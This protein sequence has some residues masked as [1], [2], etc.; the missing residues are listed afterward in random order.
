MVELQLLPLMDYSQLLTFVRAFHDMGNPHSPFHGTYATGFPLS[1]TMLP[2]LLMDLIGRVSSIETGGRVL[3]TAY[4]VGLPAAAAFLLASVGQSRWNV[5]G[6][7]P[8]V[9]GKWVN[10]G[11]FSFATGGP[12]VLLAFALA[13]RHFSKPTLR[14][15]IALALVSS[16][17]LLWHAI[18]ISEALLGVGLLWLFWRA[19]SW[20]ARWASLLPFLLPFLLGLAWYTQTFKG[21]RP[22]NKHTGG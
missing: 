21:P 10:S 8:L 13:V 3:V 1:P 11:Y 17:L 6:V 22:G 15:G 12:W 20:K 19:P 7:F 4:A 14:R 16:V 18:L 5:I 9:F 2:V